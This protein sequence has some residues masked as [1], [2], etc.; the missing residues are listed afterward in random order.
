MSGA[1]DHECNF[2]NGGIFTPCDLFVQCTRCKQQ[3]RIYASMGVNA[4]KIKEK[5]ELKN[6]GRVSREIMIIKS[7]LS[8]QK[9]FS[10]CNLHNLSR[11]SVETGVYLIS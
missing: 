3:K 2:Q 1:S 6:H 9:L 5:R 11:E 4:L 8:E 7:N 10:K